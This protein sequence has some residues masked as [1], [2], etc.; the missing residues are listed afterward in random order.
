MPGLNMLW[1]KTGP[2]HP[3]DSGGKIRS[4]NMLRELNR[5]H[6][7]IYVSLCS[8][9]CDRQVAETE[10]RTTEPREQA[11]VSRL[12]PVGRCPATSRE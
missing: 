4:Y 6:K 9:G 12:R 1:L 11:S 7:L 2:L 3:L 10:K 8:P 5:R